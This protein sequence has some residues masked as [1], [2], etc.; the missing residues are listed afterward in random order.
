MIIDLHEDCRYAQHIDFPSGEKHIRIKELVPW[1]GVTLVYRDMSGDLMKLG[2]AVDI[3]RRANVKSIELFM[4]FVPYARQDRVAVDGDPFSIKV[5]A[6]FINSL[7]LDKVTIVD[8]HSEVTPALINNVSIIH[9]HEI[10]AKAIIQLHEITGEKI[11]LVAPDLGA[12][13]KVK[14]LQAY[15]YKEYNAPYP[16]IQCDK[17]RCPETGGITGFKILEG[18]PFG[19]HCLMVD[20]IC[21]GGGTFMGLS[22]VIRENGSL[23]QSLYVTHGI[24]SKGI[25]ALSH[26][27][28]SIFM[29]DS[30]PRANG[31]H[32]IEIKV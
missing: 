13:K 1:N 18:S 29:S 10:A 23:G 26:K 9:Q 25:G 11:S 12:A 19:R 17:T 32:L 27:F 2:M 22:D 21:D 8:P 6:A 7:E 15:M 4:P 24:F 28:Q 31:V 14:A 30:L 16:I 5:F 3:C 20:D